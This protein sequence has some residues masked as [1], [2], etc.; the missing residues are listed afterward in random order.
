[1]IV[2]KARKKTVSVVSD[3]DKINKTVQLLTEKHEFS[4][5]VVLAVIESIILSLQS[6]V[7]ALTD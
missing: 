6:S 1:M 7:E 5:D 4:P 2:E 3:K